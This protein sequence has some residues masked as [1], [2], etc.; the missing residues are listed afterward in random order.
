MY[1]NASKQFSHDL[2]V[3]VSDW[4]R[5]VIWC[6]LYYYSIID[7]YITGHTDSPGQ[8]SISN[9]GK[10][11]QSATRISR[12]ILR[13]RRLITTLRTLWSVSQ[14][15]ITTK[16]WTNKLPVNI[17]LTDCRGSDLAIAWIDG[18]VLFL[19]KFCF[20]SK[21]DNWPA[22]ES[23]ILQLQNYKIAETNIHRV[24]TADWTA[25]LMNF[26]LT[27]SVQFSQFNEGDSSPES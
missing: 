27:F 5:T 22:L 7:Q 6:V 12:L 14:V 20:V 24:L 3:S 17:A 15:P 26:Q 23:E 8:V 10:L 25:L 16:T 13:I 9:D 11:K 19:L 18:S 4:S 1:I 2:S 21:L